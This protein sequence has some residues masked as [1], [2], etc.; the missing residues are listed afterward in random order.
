MA[1]TQRPAKQQAAY[2]VIFLLASSLPVL[3]TSALDEIAPVF[4]AAFFA[5]CA[6]VPYYVLAAVVLSLWRAILRRLPAGCCQPAT[7]TTV[8]LTTS[9][10]TIVAPLL[11]LALCLGN[12]HG[13]SA[14]EPMPPEVKR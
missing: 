10:G 4:D 13:A 12:S 2:V 8:P 1:L 11:L 14:A 3:L 9:T 7:T 6:L 5:A